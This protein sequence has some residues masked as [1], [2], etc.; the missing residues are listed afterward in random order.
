MD[1]LWMATMALNVSKFS[2]KFTFMVDQRFAGRKIMFF[3]AD[4]TPF[5]STAIVCKMPLIQ[6]E[7]ALH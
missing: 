7:L 4:W 1:D 6:T 5:F 3:F 2:T